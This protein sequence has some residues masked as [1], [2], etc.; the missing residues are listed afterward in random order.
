MGYRVKLQMVQRA[1]KNHSYYVNL[2]VPLIKMLG[3]EKGEEFDWS[4]QDKRT[5]VLR[6]VKTTKKK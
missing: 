5:F 1:K 4:L 6:R 2:P 3:I